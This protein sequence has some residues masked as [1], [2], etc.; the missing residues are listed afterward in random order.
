MEACTDMKIENWLMCHIYTNTYFGGVT[1][2]LVPDNLITG[3]TSN[4]RYETQLNESY[5]ELAEYYGTAIVPARVRK[6]QD[7]G[8]VEKSV[9]FSTTW[10]TAALREC[11]FFS[12]A[13][14]KEAVEKR[15]EFINTKSFQKRPGSRREVYLAEKKEFK[16]PLPKHPYEP[17]VWKQQTVRNDH[18]ISDGLNKYSVSFDL[19]G[20]HVQIRLTK[21]LIEV[22]FKGSRMASHKRLAKFSVQP[23]VKPEHMPDCHRKYLNFNA[24]EFKNWAKTVV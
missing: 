2:I 21:D 23:I 14:V 22:Y 7:K 19:I 15:L 4:T 20:E 12:F 5:R 8:L 18:L 1:R 17:S 9:G 10:I 3:V 24:D 13:E 16:L 11:K 6:P